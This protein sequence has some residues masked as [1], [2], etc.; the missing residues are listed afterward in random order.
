MSDLEA[1]AA[2][3]KKYLDVI[4]SYFQSLLTANCGEELSLQELKVVDFVGQR[5]SV[6]M[7]EAAEYMKVAVSTMTGIV[8]KLENKDLVRRERNDED[9]RIV[10]L[11]LTNKGKRLYQTYA[12]N[13][14][15]LSR[16]MLQSLSEDEQRVYLD[17]T[18]KIAQGASAF[19]ASDS[20]K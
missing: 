16:R 9:R 2:A 5:Q 7:R 12:E 15:Q 10:R 6:I 4:S 8:D 19:V 14:L 17:L 11:F 3:L 1:R 13:Y 20:G 18:G